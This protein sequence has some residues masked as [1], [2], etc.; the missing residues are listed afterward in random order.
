MKILD[1][2]SFIKESCGYEFDGDHSNDWKDDYYDN[3]EPEIADKWEPGDHTFEYEI[4]L[5]DYFMSRPVVTNKIAE[6]E[7]LI[8]DFS[9]YFDKF[10]L[11]N[12]IPGWS[13]TKPN[14]YSF[15][16]RYKFDLQKHKEYNGYFSYKSLNRNSPEYNDENT[17]KEVRANF[18]IIGWST[19]DEDGNITYFE[20]DN[21][22][23]NEAINTYTKLVNECNLLTQP[24]KTKMINDFKKI[25]DE[26]NDYI[27]TKGEDLY[28]FY[29]ED[30][31]A[32]E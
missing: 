25:F 8:F 10:A 2:N 17:V 21:K 20:L 11:D 27:K 3:R 5:W 28:V 9:K 4:D 16:T 14:A 19:L 26:I 31:Y 22:K 6:N 23:I 30:C 32:I 29:G 1:L 7:N 15:P 13:H 24:E 12:R 18:R